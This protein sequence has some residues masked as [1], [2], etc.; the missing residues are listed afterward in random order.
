MRRRYAMLAK[1]CGL[2]AAGLT[3]C[4]SALPPS[5]FAG[6]TPAMRPEIFFAGPTRSSGVLENR[7]GVPTS[8]LQVEGCGKTLADG[9]FRLDQIVHFST[10]KPEVRIWLVHR[11]DAHRY[12][13]TLTDA[14][15][16]VKAEA[17]GN[18][19]HV[20]YPMASPIGGQ[21]EE[22]MYLQPDGKTVMNETTIFVFGVVAAH[23]AERITHEAPVQPSFRASPDCSIASPSASDGAAPPAALAPP[24]SR[25]AAA[26]PTRRP[27]RTG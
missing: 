17:Y 3:G 24:A 5:A 4:S 22:W 25:P 1:L 20:L 18:L 12:E 11:I 10:G 6:G 23:L 13:G 26:D 14:S 15:G 2:G 19:F 27:A 21:L 7:S 9:S 8:R 16:P